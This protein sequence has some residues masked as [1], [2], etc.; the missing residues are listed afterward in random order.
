[1]SETQTY[2]VVTN[3]DGYVTDVTN[4]IAV[5]G[6]TK[7]LNHANFWMSKEQAEWW[8]SV[9]ARNFLP[10]YAVRE[11]KITVEDIDESIS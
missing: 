7:Y 3:K 5:G 10:P 6:T 4:G 8:I 11:V 1:M 9:M 2:Y